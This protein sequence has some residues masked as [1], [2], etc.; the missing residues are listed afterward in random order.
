MTLARKTEA[1][2]KIPRLYSNVAWA[3]RLLEVSHRI[4][5]GARIFS[6]PTITMRRKYSLWARP[7]ILISGTYSQTSHS[8]NNVYP[9]RKYFYCIFVQVILVAP[10]V[11]EFKNHKNVLSYWILCLNM[12]IDR[13]VVVFYT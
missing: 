11:A 4:Y 6:N 9:S 2:M 13:I 7:P 10:H 5:T 8:P 12:L 1:K 3:E